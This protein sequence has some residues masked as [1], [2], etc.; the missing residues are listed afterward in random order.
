MY[1]KY[2]LLMSS[3]NFDLGRYV[4]TIKKLF[5]LFLVYNFKNGSFLATAS[6]NY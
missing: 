1:V 3:K 4:F 5:V 2:Y 6:A